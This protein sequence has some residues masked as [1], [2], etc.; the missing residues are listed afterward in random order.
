MSGP[1]TP[2]ARKRDLVR[3]FLKPSREPSPA[4]PTAQTPSQS[5]SQST[6]I[7][8]YDNQLQS[9]HQFLQRALE[10][11]DPEVQETI[12]K[13]NCDNG[14]IT[15]T[16]ARVLVA[17]NDQKRT[18]EAKR[19]KWRIRGHEVDLQAVAD[20]TILWLERFKA[21]GDIAVNADPIH[22]GLPWAGLRLILEV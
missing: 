14:S 2:P 22:A 4:T 8:T 17:A 3:R 5:F 16:I 12:R 18:C 6:V 19:W 7:A 21:V 13:L 10:R 11:L 1:K 9:G 20:K 15:S